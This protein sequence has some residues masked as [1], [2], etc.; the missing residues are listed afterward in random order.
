MFL[1]FGCEYRQLLVAFAGQSE[2]LMTQELY[3]TCGICF[4]TPM[5]PVG[6]I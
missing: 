1:D 5:T 6:S 2:M 3:D 4:L